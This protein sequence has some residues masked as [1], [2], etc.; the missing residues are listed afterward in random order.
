MNRWPNRPLGEIVDFGSGSTPPKENQEFWEG[1]TPWV[2]P[3]D[4]K[5]EQLS[6]A[7][8][9]VSASGRSRGDH[10]DRDGRNS[11]S[12]VGGH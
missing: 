2:S 8:D 12:K 3:K 10:R 1:E 4:M 11:W 6:D 9:H 5:A 7:E